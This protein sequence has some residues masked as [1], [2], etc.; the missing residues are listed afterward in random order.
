VLYESADVF[1]V[2][3][4]LTL[5]HVEATFAIVDKPSGLLSCPGRDPSLYDSVQTRVPVVLPTAHGSILVHRLDQA[6][7]GLM[8]VA[9]DPETHRSLRRQFDARSVEKRYEAELIGEVRGDAGTIELPFRLDVDR[10]PHQ[11]HD[12]VHGKIGITDWEV[13]SR[14]PGRTRIGF[15]PRTG[16]THQLRVHAAHPLGLGCPI[17]GDALYGDATSAPRLLLHARTLAFD[18]PISGA[19]IT[20]ESAVPF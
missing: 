6:T 20:F 16:R 19:R 8:V 18:H 7:S 14:S 17:A 4:G 15:R 10:R 11:I 12:P 2:S 13:V 9:L 3:E 1:R 5:V